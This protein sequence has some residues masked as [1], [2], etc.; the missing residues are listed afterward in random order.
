V[1]D[2]SH[3]RVRF[4][5]KARLERATDVDVT[6]N[7]RL[8]DMFQ[9]AG[10]DLTGRARNLAEGRPVSA[11]FTTSTPSLQ[12]TAPENAVDG[13]TISGLPVQSGSYVARNP[14]WGTQGSP[15]A[16]DWFEIDLEGRR[17]F[18]TLRLYFYSNKAF[19]VGGNTYREPASY[20]VQYHDGSTWVDVPGQ[21]RTPSAPAPNFNRVEF[22]A[23]TARRVRV[24]MAPA[25]TFG[26]GLKEVQV[27]DTRFK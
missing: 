15:N 3:A 12:A 18:D 13:F 7:A 17:R 2:R 16:E 19:G 21:V 27:L 14:I 25:G 1:L 8:V 26:I 6:R 11:S 10:L 5:R 20:T 23:I 22:P 4:A 9:K 24:L